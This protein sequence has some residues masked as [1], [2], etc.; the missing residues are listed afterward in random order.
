MCDEIEDLPDETRLGDAAKALENS[1]R[2]QSILK[3][4]KKET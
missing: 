1:Y 3:K 2:I 4:L